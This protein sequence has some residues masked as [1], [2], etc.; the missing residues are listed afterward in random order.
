MVASRVA[1]N[2][3][4]PLLTAAFALSLLSL[5]L[6]YVRHD[7]LV[8]DPVVSEMSFARFQLLFDSC[9]VLVQ[10]LSLPLIMTDVFFGFI[11]ELV[12]IL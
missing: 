9:S 4:R 11:E 6:A 2:A 5:L 12:Q 8:F 3:A 7:V 10:A 1:V